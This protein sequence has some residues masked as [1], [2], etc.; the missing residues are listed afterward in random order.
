MASRG[1]HTSTGTRSISS[2]GPFKS[3]KRDYDCVSP[4]SPQM[5]PSDFHRILSEGLNPI[6]KELDGIKKS[7]ESMRH[8]FSSELDSIK[9]SVDIIK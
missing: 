3:S 9:N 8:E 6:N 4:V 5:S 7:I 1:S 2:G